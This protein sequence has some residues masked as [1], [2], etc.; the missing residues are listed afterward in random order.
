MA[1]GNGHCNAMAE[2]L[3]ILLRAKYSVLAIQSK[4]EL[5]VE[6]MVRRVC[7]STKDKASGQPFALRFWSCT[8]GIT[9]ADGEL[10]QDAREP[11]EALRYVQAT[12][13]RAIYVFRDVHHFLAD[14]VTQRALRDTARLL[15]TTPPA[16]A[17]AV[18]LLSPVLALPE[19]LEADVHM[20]EW[21]LP[22]REE[23]ALVLEQSIAGLP[24]EI[25][26]Q[27]KGADAEKVVSAALGLTAEEA[28]SAFARSLVEM[29]ALDPALIMQEK[30][31]IV[32][33]SGVLEWMEPLK[34]GFEDVGDLDEVKQWLDQ[35]RTAYTPAAVAY[36]IPTPKGVFLAGISGCGKTEIAKAVAAVWELPLLRLN[37][38]KLFGGLVGQSL[39][40]DEEVYICDNA[41]RSVRRMTVEQAHK[42]FHN[43]PKDFPW[44]TW[45]YTDWGASRV[46]KITDVLQHVRNEKL[47]RVITRSGRT[48]VVTEGHSL[49]VK[50]KREGSQFPMYGPM[51]Q[52]SLEEVETKNL[53]IGDRIAVVRKL[54]AVRKYVSMARRQ[55]RHADV[56]RSG[57]LLITITPELATLFGLYLG[58]GSLNHGLLRISCDARDK[59]TLKFL[60]VINPS[61]TFSRC[62]ASN[63]LDVTLNDWSIAMTAH[64]LNVC[65]KRQTAT[66]H[67][68]R[69][70]D[71]VF[72]CSNEIIG[73]FLRGYFS[74]DGYASSQ[75]TVE[76][77]TVNPRL[78]QDVAL[79]LSRLG[80][81]A[82]IYTKS[83]EKLHR[84]DYRINMRKGAEVARFVKRVGFI[85]AYK[86]AKL[87]NL[88][89]YNY[90][91]ERTSRDVLWDEI[92]SIEKMRQQPKYVY[93]LSV[94]KTEKF[95]SGGIV[96]HNSEQ[97][98]RKSISTAEIV[99]PCVMI[100][101]E[102]DKAVGGGGGEHDGGT[103][104][105][106][107]GELL[108]WLQDRMAPVFVVATANEIEAL[109]ERSP[110]LVRKGRWDELFFV[111]L[112]SYDGRMSIFRVHVR[113]RGIPPAQIDFD[114]LARASGGFSGAEIAAVVTDAMFRGF[115]DGARPVDTL[116]ILTEIKRTTPM[117]KS[118]ERKIESLRRWAKGRARLASSASVAET[119][120]RKLEA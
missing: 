56:V 109:S 75:N 6:R 38:G 61:A 74:A 96:V 43:V 25:K 93:D 82:R 32:A 105:R 53:L 99:A 55:Y 30:K 62:K 16:V 36:G 19:E 58:D 108:T 98:L 29:K 45:T 31:Q 60:K 46:A 26:A 69:V 91:N 57:P 1:E 118:S 34:G 50:R 86:N 49:F 111:D 22:T 33:K 71:W 70:P 18:V 54:G 12:Q 47:L 107:R 104:N 15:K 88:K 92:V 81:F 117:S 114:A 24:D 90:L 94:S 41:G 65:G 68:K 42:E 7:A 73:A 113:K 52:T 78:A 84:R 102:I 59:D 2:K 116:D 110:E 37:V 39:A 3:S 95:I 48:V 83:N 77:S 112:P 72:G 66:S 44:H 89:V 23:L 27:V 87:E 21:P 4:E 63:G 115:Q 10:L 51:R 40:P 14:P 20:V 76:A 9:D 11:V 79:L 97:N 106:V 119:A 13:E 35:R 17:R 100:I 80:I 8:Q 120:T 5:R 85:Q 67:T 103:T 101:D 64:V 28:Y